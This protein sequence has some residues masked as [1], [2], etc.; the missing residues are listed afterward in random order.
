MP[1]INERLLLTGVTPTIANL[2]L[3]NAN[4]EY[5]YSVPAY[6]RQFSVKTRNPLHTVKIAFSSGQ[7]N[8]NY[9]TLDS[10]S[11]YESMILAV[12][13]VF[14]CQSPDAGCV[15]EIVLWS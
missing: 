14:Y 3:T 13:L 5:S 10:S 6:T 4:T 2:T 9:F 8:T 7:S 1:S 15:L 11:W 12:N